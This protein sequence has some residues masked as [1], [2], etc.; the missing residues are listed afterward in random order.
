MPT[1]LFAGATGSGKSQTFCELQ[2]LKANANTKIKFFPEIATELLKTEPSEFCNDKD[3][4]QTRIAQLQLAQLN[5][6]ACRKSDVIITDRGLPDFYVFHED[7]A[8]KFFTSESEAFSYYDYVFFF[9]PF[10]LDDVLQGNALRKEKS[11]IEI[12]EIA[13]K[14]ENV[15][16]RYPHPQNILVIPNF[17]TIE[18]KAIYCAK[19]L[20]KVLNDTIF[21]I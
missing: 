14:T 16:K 20:N 19:M 17:P 5:D 7:G 6:E 11:L 15:Y 2:N 13:K 1:I 21:L 4:F 3:K 9:Q 18:E 12:A 8:K 10:V